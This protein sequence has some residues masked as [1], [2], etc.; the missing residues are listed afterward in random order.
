VGGA[1]LSFDANNGVP[2]RTAIYSSDSSS[3]VL[4][5]AVSEI[6]FGAVESSVFAITPPADAKVQEVTFSNEQRRAAAKPGN[7]ERPAL[8]T[9]GHGPATVAVLASPRHGEAKSSGS[10]GAGESLEG[11]SKVTIDGT[12]AGE[13]RTEL[14]TLL[15]FERSGVRYLLAGAVAPAAVEEIARGL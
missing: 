7:G 3:P 12:A 5:L 8:T 13:L 10:K 15:T 2:L 1:E 11:L 9:H 14:G 6:S 4:E